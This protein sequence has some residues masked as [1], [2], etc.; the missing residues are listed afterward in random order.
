MKRKNISEKI[1]EI[2]FELNEVFE[3]I[4]DTDF[5]TWQK[6]CFHSLMLFYSGLAPATGLSNQNTNEEHDP[7]HLTSE[8]QGTWVT[9]ICH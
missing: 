2:G 5:P 9:L 8:A 6:M 3:I 4:V 1:F 7:T